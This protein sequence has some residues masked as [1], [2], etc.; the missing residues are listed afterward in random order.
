MKRVV[1]TG[2][3]AVSALG[4]SVEENWTNVLAGFSNMQMIEH[5][6]A[7]TYATRFAA[8][9]QDFDI[10]HL[11][12]KK[13]QRKMDAFCL[14]AIAAADEA[15]KDSNIDVT[16]ANA[17]RV[18][19]CVGS[20]IGGIGAFE[21]AK[22]TIENRGVKRVSPFTIPSI[23]INMAAGHIS[24]RYGLRGPNLAVTTAC[25]TGTH[26]LTLAAQQIQLGLADVMVAGG[27][28]KASETVG[29]AG[30]ASARA[31]STRNDE[32]NK[33]S[34]PWDKDRDGFVLGDG[35]GIV[36]LEELEH[37]KARGA[38]IYAELSGYGMSGDAYHMTSPEP[39]G[40]GAEAAMRNALKNAAI[41]ADK[42]DYI[43]AHGTSTPAGDVIE[44]SAIKRIFGE[45][46]YNLAVSS[47]KSMTGHLLG[48]AGAIEAIYTILAVKHN[49]APPTINHDTPEDGCDLNF[50]PYKAQEKTIDVAISNSFG[51]GGT[52]GSLVFSK[53]Q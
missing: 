43:N 45:H 46:A 9:V 28:E 27:A 4:N 1:I 35:A 19:I 7:S 33:A 48:A 50:V 25:T 14:Y 42:I 6:D 18:G 30:F 34:R 5:F 29:M 13:D 38:T 12:S 2:L 24:M 21:Q 36:V 15:L 52:N 8:M 32:P 53:Y 11:V 37:A 39:E 16:E 23:I 22:L 3:G 31:M 47:T 51:F 17:D 44:V 40:K 26:A 10:E 20:G 49:I 41:A